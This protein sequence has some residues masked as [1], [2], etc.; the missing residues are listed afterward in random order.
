VPLRGFRR[1]GATGG[2][3]PVECEVN[4]GVF[5]SPLQ[6]RRSLRPL[7][8][9]RAPVPYPYPSRPLRVI[10]LAPA[11]ALVEPGPRR[12]GRRGRVLGHN[13]GRS[14]RT[15]A[16]R[17]L[18]R[19]WAAARGGLAPG[20]QANRRA[21]RRRGCVREMSEDGRPRS[22]RRRGDDICLLP[23]TRQD[24]TAPCPG[25]GTRASE[26]SRKRI[27][28]IVR[29]YAVRMVIHLC[30]RGPG[31]DLRAQRRAGVVGSPGPSLRR[32][33]FLPNARGPSPSWR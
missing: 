9:R 27:S 4:G 12:R 16:P 19:A 7:V 11:S 2:Q 22:P 8:H 17:H 5:E 3:V 21:P 32:C 18:Y 20:A 23:R 1:G 24:E 6:R 28:T 14:Q 10:T 13:T 30:R 26:R 15:P 25:G 29:G 31:K 33:A